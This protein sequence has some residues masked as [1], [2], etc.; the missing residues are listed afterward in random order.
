MRWKSDRGKES[1]ESISMRICARPVF[2]NAATVESKSRPSQL[3]PE[4][5]NRREVSAWRVRT[6]PVGCSSVNQ[7]T[8]FYTAISTISVGE[9]YIHVTQHE[10]AS[11]AHAVASHLGQ[12]PDDL[13]DEEFND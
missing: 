5:D 1:A 4:S 13:A 9:G 12:L 7:H 11:P 6:P 10:A 8:M 2:R 3:P